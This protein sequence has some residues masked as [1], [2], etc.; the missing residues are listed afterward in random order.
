MSL[1][2]QQEKWFA[3][4]KANLERETGKTLDEWAD[5]ARQCPQTAHRARLAWMKETYGLGQNRAS[6][7]LAHAFPAAMSWR[8]PDA[9][10]D[11]LWS[12]PAQRAVYDAVADL[13][14]QLPDVI[15]GARKTFV[16]FSRKVQFAAIKPA[17]GGALLGLDVAPD[18]DPRLA[19]AR[20]EGWSERLKSTL[21]LESPDQADA[22]LGL[23]LKQAW[24][25][26]G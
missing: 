15:V 24:T 8:E 4:V 26:A 1:T 20:K 11:Q 18:A 14:L 22:A 17:K 7:V 12:D 13:V 10:L 2:E 25:S 16:G 6:V 3:S 23:L 9:L 5:L 21:R 19:P